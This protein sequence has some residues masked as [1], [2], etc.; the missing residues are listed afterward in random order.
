MLGMVLLHI[1]V[2]MKTHQT[3]LLSIAMALAAVSLAAERQKR[4][5]IIVDSYHSEFIWSQNT[6]RGCTEA[7]LEKGYLDDESQLDELMKN[8]Y[9]QSSTTVFRKLWMDTK[10]KNSNEEISISARQIAKAIRQF[11]PDLIFLGDDNAANFIGNQFL[12]SDIPIVFWG[13]NMTPV[14]YGLVDSEDRP[15]HNATGVFQKTYYKESLEFLIKIVPTTKTFAVLSNATT[16]GRVHV[17]AIDFL[18]EQGEL[19]LSLIESVSTNSFDEWKKKALELQKKVDSFFIAQPSGLKDAEGKLVPQEDVIFWFFN[20]ISIPESSGF[21]AMVD[22]GVLCAVDDS[23]YNQGF[24][25]ALIANDIL[26]NGADPA[27]YPPRSPKRGPRVV[28]AQ[29]AAKLGIPLRLDMGIEQFVRSTPNPVEKKR[30][31]VIDSYYR[32]HSWS[33]DVNNGFCAAMLALGYFDDNEQIKEFTQNDFVETSSVVV[34]KYWMDS[35]RKSGEA[36]HADAGVSLYGKIMDFKPDIIFVG[37]DNAALHV[38]TKFIDSAIPIVFWGLN[39]TPVK[40]GLVDDEKKPGHNVTGVYQ[41]S[42]YM[43]SFRLLKRLAPK[44]K[45]LAILS[46][47]STTARIHTKLVERLFLENKLGIQLTE[48]VTTDRYKKWKDKALEL[49]G[50]VDA[51]FLAHFSGLKDEKGNS[52]AFEEVV[53]W[54]LKNIMIP[55]VVTGSYVKNGFLCAAYDSGNKQGFEAVLIAHDILANGADPA[56]YPPRTPGR[57]PLTVNLKRAEMLGITIS[58]D[59]GVEKLIN[60][61]ESNEQ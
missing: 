11:K 46:D 29:R 2:Q 27:T 20:N 38:G 57:G 30:L 8:D 32:D 31:I 26:A 53:G 23:D 59:M 50:K 34:R 55:E 5:I 9:A 40:Y 48:V 19:P 44:I 15:G 4:K 24:E 41:S 37:D 17:K 60:G 54:Y 6:Q 51:F 28:N 52:V 43:D 35:K 12:D 13:V 39:N 45:T 58:D 14:K 7:L 16:T 10:R 22:A 56:V 42:H 21:K 18:Y 25:A 1:G 47:G 36:E 61:I 49:R 33:V 3:I